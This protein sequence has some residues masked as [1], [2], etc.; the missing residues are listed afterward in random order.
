MGGPDRAEADHLLVMGQPFLEPRHPLGV[1][2]HLEPP[3]LDLA[4]ED[5][6]LHRLAEFEEVRELESVGHQLV[7]GLGDRRGGGDLLRA[8]GVA[9][10]EHPLGPAEPVD[11]PLQ[12][13]LVER[14]LAFEEPGVLLDQAVAVFLDG[15]LG[16]LEA[17]PGL[18]E[19]GPRLLGLHQLVEDHVLVFGGV[20]PA[21]DV[22]LLDG[23]PLL[24]DLEDGGRPARGHA[25]PLGPDL[26]PLELALDDRLVLALD[27][28]RGEEPGAQVDPRDQPAGQDVRRVGPTPGPGLGPLEGPEAA[29]GHHQG[30]RA[31]GRQPRE[32]AAPGRQGGS[33]F[34]RAGHGGETPR[35]R[36]WGE[37][38]PAGG[39]EAGEAGR[40]CGI[41]ML[42]AGNSFYSGRSLKIGQLS[43][44]T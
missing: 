15:E 31:P 37:P 2:D 11:R 27:P 38:T 21:E 39:Y 19:G 41:G 17:Q 32:P 8:G 10:V 5:L 28:A 23:G 14:D 42:A 36:S 44:R 35:T 6:Q 34:V 22:A 18:L 4:E 40:F 12:V 13:R 16:D 1:G 29:Q 24:D 33:L 25:V 7:A 3:L 43:I 30:E 26:E 9:L 20:E